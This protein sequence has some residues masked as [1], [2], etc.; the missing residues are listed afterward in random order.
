[1]LA[2]LIPWLVVGLGVLRTAPPPS[3]AVVTLTAE[4]GVAESTT[5]LL[6]DV[7]LQEL[8]LIHI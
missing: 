5:R 1:M 8:S 4:Q 2:V 6:T 7:L 3:L